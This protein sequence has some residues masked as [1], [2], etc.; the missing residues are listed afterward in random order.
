VFY[1]NDIKPIYSEVISR[2]DM[3]SIGQHAGDIFRIARM[4]KERMFRVEAVLK[5]GRYRFDSARAA[6]QLAV[7]RILRGFQSDP[8]PVI[9]AAAL[10]AGGLTLEEYRGIH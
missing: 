5:L 1:D 2:A 10:G 4:S 3:Q 6:D 9:R 7:P 8:D